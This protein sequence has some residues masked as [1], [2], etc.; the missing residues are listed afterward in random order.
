M[1]EPLNPGAV[2]LYQY[3]VRRRKLRRVPH[4]QVDG[5]WQ[6]A[7]LFRMTLLDQMH[8]EHFC[9]FFLDVRQVLVGFELV[10]VGSAVD[11]HVCPREVFRGALLAGAYQIVLSHNHPSGD[12]T[13]SNEDDEL[14]KRMHAAGVVLGISIADHVIVTETGHYSYRMNQRYPWDKK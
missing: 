3:T 2:R 5:S 4:G 1:D 7:E 14:T 12:S 9:C 11:V 6:A 13:P 8:R 10:A